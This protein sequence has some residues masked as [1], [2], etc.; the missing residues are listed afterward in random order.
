MA[1]AAEGVTGTTSSRAGTWNIDPS[2]SE[3]DFTV[4]HLMIS[5]DKPDL[6]ALLKSM[7]K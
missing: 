5:K 2:H 6:A 4:T 3:V 1:A 7:G